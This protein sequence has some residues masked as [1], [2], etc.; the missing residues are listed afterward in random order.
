[1]KKTN[2]MRILDGMGFPYDIKFYDTKDGKLDGVSVSEKTGLD[3]NVV[4]KTLVCK[5]INSYFVFVIPVIK[6]LDLK[7][8]AVA[9]TVKKIEMIHKKDL[10][11]V[12]GYQP[13]GCSPIAMKKIFPTFIDDSA[14]RSEKIAVS[15]GQVGAQ[16]ILNPYHL[17]K[18]TA[19]HWANLVVDV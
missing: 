5:N 6:T 7:K 12:T 1:M 15:A 11:G 9:A 14:M 4:F 18:A 16:I 10:K 17:I 13:G 8:A 2:A 3:P 19:A